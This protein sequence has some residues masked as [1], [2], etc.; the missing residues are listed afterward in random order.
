MKDAN[1]IIIGAGIVGACAAYHLAKMGWRDILVVDK[2]DLEINDG[3][4]SHAPGGVVSMSHNKLMAEMSVY[5]S[6]LYKSLEPYAGP[7]SDIYGKNR[8]TYNAVGSL[9]VAISKRR[10]QDLVREHG[11]ALSY[12]IEA[13]LLD[14]KET[15]E[16]V[17]LINPK[18]IVGSLFIPKSAL[19][20]GSNTTLAL[21]RDASKHGAATF[22]GHTE[23][24]DF[25][26][27]KGRIKGVI[28]NNPEMPTI[29]ADTVLLCTN[30]WGPVLGDKYNLHL[31]LMAFE[32]QYTITEPLKE[33]AYFDPN[34]PDHE[35]VFPTM[36]ELDSAMYIRN[37]WNSLGVGNYQHKPL[38][39][40][41]KDIK[42]NAI[43]PF[44][45][46]DFKN[47]WSQAI[48]LFP[49]LKGKKLVKK[50]NGMF[51]F[52]IDGMPII[53]E[54]HIKGLWTAIA[55]WIT[56]AGG[57][58]KS[59]AEWM[60][61]GETEWDMRQC[62]IHRF[63]PFATTD[64]YISVVSSKNYREVYELIHPKQPP[65]E[66]RN[67]R[68]SP[69]A[70]RLEQLKV[71]HTVFAGLELP[72]WF[73]TNKNLLKTFDKKIPKRSGWAAEHWS[74]IQGA[75]HLA[76]RKNVALF[77]LTGLSIIEVKGRKALEYVNYLCSN[78]MNKPVG[79]VVYTCWLTPKGGVKRD[80]AVARIAEDTFWM[81][82]GEGTRPQ[83][84]D[85]VVN[86]APKDGISINDISDGY[87]ALGLWG[88]KARKVLEQ[89]A[90]ADI[91]NEAFPYFTAQWINIGYAK[92]L[93]L[94]LSYAGELGWELHFSNEQA[95]PV[96]D[97]LWKAGQK[98]N[99]IA[100]GMGAFDSLRLEKGYR[101]W[102]TDLHTE[103]NP[104]E[105]G[106][107]WTVRLKKE[108]FIGKKACEK[109]KSQA[110]KKKLC[111]LTL[112]KNAV[113]MGYEPIMHGDECVGY[114]TSANYGYSVGKFMAYGY[115]PFELANE[116]TKLEVIY[117]GKRYKAV[118]A[119]EPLFDAEMKRLKG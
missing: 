108:N 1:V 6:D 107:G 33:L 13:H 96:W 41:P 91:S 21:A 83:D 47:A 39:V 44:T 24:T 117:F 54:S 110:L 118:V 40:R 10:F 68:L 11:E 69:F 87:T 22:V 58:T 111:C 65:S 70:A 115:L 74:R 61:Y 26:I 112:D 2:G 88:P 32:H 95:L 14:A 102:G 76:T 103:Y 3:S 86:N 98:H 97:T 5:T 94:R 43:R 113:L 45:P 55:S 49:A 25:I 28:T 78:Q 82:I 114:V 72:N 19:I 35:A 29:Q 73:E 50:F 17:P 57:V 30:I 9:E 4:S 105:A 52:S 106:L 93:A 27:D 59:V 46:L 34:N 79:S 100:A 31:P 101:G 81:F 85:W 51:A 67:V 75:E 36:R 116:G 56:H 77:D 48:H 80:L 66:P 62:H 15:Q 119:N 38:M 42:G 63:L 104:Y 71:V 23:V 12:H 64:R 99:I 18:A 20:G 109:I 8:K 37:H 60:T 84:L 16:K 7:P 92:V 89:V 53:G 90:S